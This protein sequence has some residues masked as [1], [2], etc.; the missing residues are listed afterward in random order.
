MIIINGSI[1]LHSQLNGRQ[2]GDTVPT[3]AGAVPGNVV[4]LAE[5]EI[6]IMINPAV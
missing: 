2:D 6:D 4:D 3:T 5:E 1:G